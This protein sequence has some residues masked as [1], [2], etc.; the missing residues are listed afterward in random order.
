MSVSYSSWE[1][2][3]DLASKYYTR[4]LPIYYSIEHVRLTCTLLT[5]LLKLR[6]LSYVCTQTVLNEPIYYNKG[7]IYISIPLLA[8]LVNKTVEM[9]KYE[10]EFLRNVDLFDEPLKEEYTNSNKRKKNR[11]NKKRRQFLSDNLSLNGLPPSKKY[12]NNIDSEIDK[13]GY[14]YNPD[15]SKIEQKVDKFNRYGNRRGREHFDTLDT[16]DMIRFQQTLRIIGAVIHF[17]HHYNKRNIS[18]L[19]T[20]H[21]DFN[22]Y[23]ECATSSTS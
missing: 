16:E 6:E 14:Y 9:P 12:K 2:I 5:H 10:V 18:S 4:D 19:F 11:K 21:K 17:I 7:I 3:V 15:T 22:D 1:S 23:I 20:S 8:M 13:D